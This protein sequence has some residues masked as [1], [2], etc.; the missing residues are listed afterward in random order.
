MIEFIHENIR[1]IHGDCN[2]YMKD[3][4]DNAFDLAIV[5][6]PYGINFGNYNRTHDDKIGR[7]HKKK[8]NCVGGQLFSLYLA[9]L[10]RPVFYILV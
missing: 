2:D 4:P 9:V 6:P 7:R 5:D 1:L 10:W 8:S 3:L